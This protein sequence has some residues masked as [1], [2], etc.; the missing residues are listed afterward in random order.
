MQEYTVGIFW[1]I[2]QLFITKLQ[3][4]EPDNLSSK[5]GKVDSDF[6]HF[7][8]WDTLSTAFP[9][10]DFATFP[11]GRVIYDLDCRKYI[12]YSDICIPN[13]KIKRFAK[14][15]NLIPFLINRDEH[16]HCDKCLKNSK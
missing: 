15:N 13:K 5:T 1:Y 12:I 16:Y 7:Y 6:S 10:A 9:Y 4:K 11:R 8:M 14:R 3:R 2:D